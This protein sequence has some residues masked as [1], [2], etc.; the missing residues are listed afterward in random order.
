MCLLRWARLY[1]IWCS[2]THVVAPDD[3]FRPQMTGAGSHFN[4]SIE[5]SRSRGG[6]C[7]RRSVA[8]LP[9]SLR[10]ALRHNSRECTFGKIAV[11]RCTFS[12]PVPFTPAV[13]CPR[14][15]APLRLQYCFSRPSIRQVERA[16]GSRAAKIATVTFA[17]EGKVRVDR[18]RLSNYSPLTP[19][20]ISLPARVVINS[21]AP[22]VRD[23]WCTKA[24][25]A[26]AR[27]FLPSVEALAYGVSWS[28]LPHILWHPRQP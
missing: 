17:K 6:K 18:L 27:F 19:E 28:T 14:C 21:Q 24:V 5:K 15:R 8:L 20:R 1:A 25:A 4:A 7:L 9:P 22:P 13:E 12:T 3:K 26:T 16:K 23:L 2:L 10:S 11:P